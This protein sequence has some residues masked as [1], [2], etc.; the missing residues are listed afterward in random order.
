[1]NKTDL[2][3][4]GADLDTQVDSLSKL[5][6]LQAAKK[7]KLASL[8]ETFPT[9]D[10]GFTDDV[11]LGMNDADSLIT[12]NAGGNTREALGPNDYGYDAVEIAHPTEDG[13]T[14]PIDEV[15]NNPWKAKQADLVAKITGKS[16]DE[17]TNQD[18][19]DVGNMQQI[20][21]L[22]DLVREPGEER[23]IAPFVPNVEQTNLT[24]HY[25]DENGKPIDIP[26]NI[27]IKSKYVGQGKYRPLYSFGNKA[28]ENVTKMHYNDPKMN[29]NYQG[30]EQLTEADR[31]LATLREK[32]SSGQYNVVNEYG[33][34]GAYQFG[35]QRLQD[36]GLVKKGATNKDL[37]NPDVWTGKYGVTS[38]EMFLN[39][40]DVQDAVALKHLA[41]L[42]KQLA[43]S[44]TSKKD[45]VG[46]IFAAHLLGVNGSKNLSNV[47]AN[48][49]SGLDYYKLGASLVSEPEIKPKNSY[50]SNMA[51]NV[52]ADLSTFAADAADAIADAAGKFSSETY[53]FLTGKK[54]TKDDLKLFGQ[55]GF[56]VDKDGLIS[57]QWEFQKRGQSTDEHFKEVFGVDNRAYNK[58]VQEYNEQMDNVMMDDSLSATEKTVM[59]AKIAWNHLD[60]IPQAVSSSLTYVA[61]LSNPYTAGLMWAG[62]TNN[63]LEE[64]KKISGKNADATE[65]LTAGAITAVELGTDYIA[66]RLTLGVGKG[67]GAANKKFVNAIFSKLPKKNPE[68]LIAGIIKGVA[69]RAAGVGVAATEEGLTESAQEA[70]GMLAERIG[71]EK[72]DKKKL[73]GLLDEE[74]QEQIEKQA[75][76]E[77]L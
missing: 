23:W 33:Y 74:S 56:S 29:A 70:L 6:S 65:A 17:L 43:G 36:L 12:K 34:V 57:H 59:A 4:A 28:G 67:L 45:L 51:K 5:D 47:D 24:G 14:K 38:R 35:A 19:I 31:L 72:F 52:E 46:K 13:F 73:W 77:R 2:A 68:G 44:A 71:T 22:A 64:R 58:S 3:L 50:I 69:K 66:G 39:R 40:P 32:E 30:D 20:Q 11:L 21:K 54:V 8:Q 49:T 48:S 63:H 7:E 55:I 27:P 75:T 18:Y 76:W 25:K 37:T 53:E 41:M 61:A 10:S 1:M 42:E 9:T 26:L 16:V 60:I 15:A 62:A